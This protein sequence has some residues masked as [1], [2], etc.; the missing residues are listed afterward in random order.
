MKSRIIAKYGVLVLFLAALFILS[1]C[2]SVVDSIGKIDSA[3]SRTKAKAGQSVMDAAGVG[4]M[5]DAMVASMVYA[6]VFFAGGYMYGY[7][8]MREG[9]GVIWKLTS[10]DESGSQSIEI[11]RALLKKNDDGTAWWLL[12]YTD[13]GQEPF[14]SEAFLDEDYSMVKFRYRD[15][16][17]G[18]IREWVP[19]QAEDQAVEDES[20]E[21]EEEVTGYAGQEALYR[22]DYEDYIVGTEKVT[23]DFGTYPSEHVLIEDSYTVYTDEEQSE[24]SSDCSS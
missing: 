12:K 23:T 24:F 15:Q 16:E 3:V 10:T 13:P 11:E 14:V 19:E 20:G 2:T 4:A 9:Y 17:T 8:D 21:E 18:D 6:Q 1:S 7:E 22:G 5:E